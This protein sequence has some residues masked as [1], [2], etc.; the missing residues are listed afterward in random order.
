M[1]DT[2]GRE[3]G[4]DVL[5]AHLLLGECRL[6]RKCSLYNKGTNYLKH[7]VKMKSFVS[8]FTIFCHLICEFLAKWQTSQLQI[9]GAM[10]LAQ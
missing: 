8:A 2:D 3:G 6:L 10:R 7:L 1:T 5:R 9:E 4:Q